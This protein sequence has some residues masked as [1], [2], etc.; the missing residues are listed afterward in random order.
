MLKIKSALIAV[1]F[2][3]AGCS[4]NTNTIT[5]VMDSYKGRPVSNWGQVYGAANQSSQHPDGG[6]INTYVTRFG[7]GTFCQVNLTV[8]A[9]GIVTFWSLNSVDAC[10]FAHPHYNP[11]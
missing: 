2:L 4:L 3:V 6:R 8:D 10:V 11:F 5:A 1:G 7:D 9:S